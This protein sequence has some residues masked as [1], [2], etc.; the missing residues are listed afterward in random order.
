M[1]SQEPSVLA[2]AQ[3]PER[4]TAFEG[5]SYAQLT[6][7]EKDIVSHR[8]MAMRAMEQGLADFIEPSQVSF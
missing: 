1:A 3:A 8:G 6:D 4:F 5:R 2:K 7:E